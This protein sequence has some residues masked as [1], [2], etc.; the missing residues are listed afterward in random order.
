MRYTTAIVCLAMGLTAHQ[1]AAAPNPACSRYQPGHYVRVDDDHVRKLDGLAALRSVLSKD[2]RNLKGV[3]YAVPWGLVEKSKGVYDFSRLDAALAQAKAKNKYLV[4]KWLDRTFWTTCNSNFIP[5]YVARAPAPAEHIAVGGFS[6]T[7]WCSA[8]IWETETM[9]HEIRVLRAIATR[10]KDDSYFVGIQMNDEPNISAEGQTTSAQIKQLYV[11]LRRKNAE[12]HAVAPNLTLIQSFNWPADG[13]VSNFDG[14]VQGLVD[15][16]GGG[17]VGMPDI[18]PSKVNSWSWY[19]IARNNKDRLFIFPEM[20]GTY[21]VNDPTIDAS[22]VTWE[23]IVKFAIDDLGAHAVVWP[24]SM[25]IGGKYENNYFTDVALYLMNKY[26][27]VTT[28]ACPWGEVGPTPTAAVHAAEAP[29][30]SA[31]HAGPEAAALLR[32]LSSLPERK[33]ARCLTGQ[34]V[35]GNGDEEQARQCFREHVED[36]ERQTGKR[37]A[38]LEYSLFKLDGKRLGP[39]EQ[40]A[41]AQRSSSAGAKGT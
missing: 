14:L 2:V 15:M 4:L 20:Q 1:A 17:A 10:Y 40:A 18:V 35:G 33:E 21:F 5:A 30:P 11:Q 23:K 26:P 24:H 39:E 36:L 31:P 38:V 3:M 41:M 12:V 16:N 27:T 29:R 32:Y 13:D 7:K 34:M 22:R 28:K 19:Q 25:P 6:N 9:N 8:R 37:P